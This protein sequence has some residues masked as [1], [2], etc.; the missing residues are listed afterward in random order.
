MG[1]ELD[2]SLNANGRRARQRKPTIGRCDAA[3]FPSGHEGSRRG[4]TRAPLRIAEA[5][6]CVCA[7]QRGV[8]RRVSVHCWCSLVDDRARHGRVSAADEL[9]ATR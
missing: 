9:S 8:S 3:W 6:A 2:L 4:R 7:R 1:R 5:E